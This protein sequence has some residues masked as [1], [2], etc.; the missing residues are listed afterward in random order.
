M[1]QFATYFPSQP[2]I[3]SPIPILGFEL[4]VYTLSHS[5]IPFLFV[6]GFYHRVSRTIC[7]GW[8]QATVFLISASWVARI[9]AVS[10]WHPSQP[11][12]FCNCRCG[13]WKG[14]AFCWYWDL[15]SGPHVC[16]NHGMAA[17]QDKHYWFPTLIGSEFNPQ[18]HQKKK[19]A[20][21]RWIKVQGK[22]SPGKKFKRPHV[23]K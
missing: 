23:S 12:V 19:E 15:N 11:H 20:E 9:T 1:C 22:P 5:T 8:V 16:V 6:M 17:A 10:H 3:Y 14:F 4:K 13:L 7:P 2:H 21:I 18:Y